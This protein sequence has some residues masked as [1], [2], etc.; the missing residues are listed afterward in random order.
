MNK[1]DQIQVIRQLIDN[2]EDLMDV[3]GEDYIAM[4]ETIIDMFEHSGYR[5]TIEK[6][7]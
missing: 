2:K 7:K 3:F 6:I 4:T 5:L 1:L